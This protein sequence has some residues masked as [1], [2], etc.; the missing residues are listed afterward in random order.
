MSFGILLQRLQPE[1]Q[2]PDA[3][4]PAVDLAGMAADRQ[5][6]LADMALAEL[7][8]LGGMRGLQA[9]CLECPLRAGTRPDGD[10]VPRAL[11]GNWL[12]LLAR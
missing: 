9:Y 4:Y 7:R 6:G 10:T 2:E 1:E 5:R 3:A 11:L 8:R 12:G